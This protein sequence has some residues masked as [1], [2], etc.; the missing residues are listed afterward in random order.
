[1][2]RAEASARLSMRIPPILPKLVVY[3]LIIAYYRI[4]CNG[5]HEKS[6]QSTFISD[7]RIESGSYAEYFELHI[8]NV[9]RSLK[10]YHICNIQNGC[11]TA[12]N[13]L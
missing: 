9:T 2:L 3:N 6:I 1:M 8:D 10:S 11:K 7:I 4:K 13:M 12:R 5:A